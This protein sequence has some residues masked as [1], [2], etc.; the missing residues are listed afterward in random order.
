MDEIIS[1]GTAA[2]RAEALLSL[3]DL[4]KAPGIL[5]FHAWWGLNAFF[6]ETAA[7]LS[8]EGF[9]VLAPDYFQGQIATTINEAKTLRS[10]MDRKRTYALAKHALEALLAQEEVFPKQVA[11]IGFSLGCGPAL[12]LARSRPDHVR[13]VVLF[14]GTGGGKFDS[15]KAD[16]LGHF[17]EDDQWGVHA[18]KVESL[19]ERLLKSGGEVIFHTYPNTRH[20]FVESD[21]PE[22][23]DEDAARIAWERTILFLN[24]KL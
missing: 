18:K 5:I 13:A 6:K 21:R 20:W 7:R 2:D 14:Y 1:I 16:F 23:Y 24:Q 4:N 22:S 8:E 17:A 19:R 15:A 10:R 12:E 11:V 3:P 9:V